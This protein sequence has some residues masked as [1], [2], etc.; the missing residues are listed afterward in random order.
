MNCHISKELF[1]AVFDGGCFDKLVEDT[2][3]YTQP[4]I[5]MEGSWVNSEITINDFFFDCKEWALSNNFIIHSWTLGN[6]SFANLKN[7]NT[8][9]I[10]ERFLAESEQ[11]AVFDACEKIL[12]NKENQCT[13]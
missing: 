8:G 10:Q 3:Y 1:E 6:S 7:I 5:I 9:T 4:C 11:Q 2:I 13:K 12:S